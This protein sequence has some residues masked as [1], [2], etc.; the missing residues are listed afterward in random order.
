MRR[1]FR[2]YR[3]RK[4]SLSI[5]QILRW[6]DAHHR[7][8]GRWP[9]ES[10][11][12]VRDAPGEKWVN[13]RVSLARGQ[14][15]LPGGSS[16]ARLLAERRGVRNRMD[17]PALSEAKVLAWADDH[18]RRT[19]DWPHAGSGRVLG[20]PG[21]VWSSVDAS[22]KQGHRG[23]PGGTSLARLLVEKRGVAN[24]QFQ[25]PLTINKILAWADAHRQRTGR[26]PK[27]NSG[28]VSTARGETW[29]A[30]DHC[31]LRGSRGLP[32]GSSLARLLANRRGV[33]NP[34]DLPRL[35][36]ER[37]LAWADRHV[38]RTGR[39]PNLNSG[40]VSGA[41]GERWSAIH[42]SLQQGHR[43]LAGGSSL[44]RL[45]AARRGVRNIKAL[46]RLSIHKI[47]AW[48]DSHH[49]RTG[50]WPQ[51][52]AGTV[53]YAPGESWV[54]V[55]A[56]LRVGGRGLKR[57]SSLAR[58]L[59]KHRG[60][61]NSKYPPQLTIRQI[62]AWAKAHRRRTGAWPSARAEPV[63]DAPGETWFNLDQALRK[64]HRGL[65]GGIS[66]ALMRPVAGGAPARARRRITR[67]STRS[68]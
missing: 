7:Q 22:L 47:L 5:E 38:R 43:G 14:R 21:E 23:L 39:W 19:R 35:T 68:P 13:L 44:A 56:M 60:V 49:R 1:P 52:D 16:L 63:R 10:S 62:M 50:T 11:G 27:R 20:A 9:S 18:L 24:P 48:A 33:P 51:H 53:L 42:T 28:A 65:P 34:M 61:R 12:A 64:G 45:L 8:T 54:N 40:A 37:I 25:P 46:P 57:G 59:T 15:G 32:G 3:Q 58:L 67:G 26:W 30:V 66:L 2:G 31:L 4:P 17:L 55:D 41:P 29:M 6:A 36:H